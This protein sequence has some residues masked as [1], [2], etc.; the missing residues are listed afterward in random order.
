MARPTSGEIMNQASLGWRFLRGKNPK[1]IIAFGVGFICLLAPDPF[2]HTGLFSAPVGARKR[3]FIF[4]GRCNFHEEE[5]RRCDKHTG[6]GQT[7]KT[8]RGSHRP[9]AAQRPT[10]RLKMEAG[11]P[12]WWPWACRGE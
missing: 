9:A 3:L 10:L 12:K 7:S 11:S 4:S 1:K 8:T 5:L 6:H 2:S